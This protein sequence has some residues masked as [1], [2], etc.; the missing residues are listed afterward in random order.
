MT[1]RDSDPLL[2]GVNLERHFTTLLQRRPL[3]L[4]AEAAGPVACHLVGGALRDA[5]L[6][7]EFRDLDLVIEHDGLTFA[8][9]LASS[10]PA[11][12]V[13]LGGDRFA[14]YRL[15]ADD[16]TVDIWDRQG[17]ALEAD[18]ARRDLTIHSF[19]LEIPDAT[20]V[21][22]FSG[23]IDLAG[24]SL[25]ATS[26]TS[27]SSDPLRVLRLAR[28]AGQLPGFTATERTLELATDSAADLDRVP[29]ERIRGELEQLLKLPGF[30]SAAE[31]LLQL[32]L[33]PGLWLSQPGHGASIP[34][35][36]E[37]QSRLRHL[38]LLADHS[39]GRVERATARQ[40]VLFAC[41][42]S[43]SGQTV[44]GTVERC[45]RDGL[46]TRASAKRLKILMCWDGLPRDTEGQRWFLHRTGSLWPTVACFLAARDERPST[47]SEY[48]EVMARLDAICLESGEEVF[49]PKPLV[50][51]ADLVSLLGLQENRVLGE[52]LATLLRQQIEGRLA[53]QD[54]AM[55]LAREL[56]LENPDTTD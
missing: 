24:R 14:A 42:P 3:V 37:L 49:E 53:S 17:V 22:P 26:E 8:S 5:A 46:L 50:T 43:S 9:Q 2:H 23:L 29:I 15:V 45:Q 16:L 56:A 6:G 35:R 54:E 55:A 7:L 25:R 13:K 20:V 48:Q 34:D 10:L 21:D 12:L 38:E 39:R 51:G 27:F 1:H 47:L 18:L 28:F 40:A 31:I 52:I 36:E 44:A 19:A 30:L 33:Y 11:R 32:N 41:L 4:A